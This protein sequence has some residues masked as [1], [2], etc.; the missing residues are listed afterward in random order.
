MP[1]SS[2]SIQT[3]S[4]QIEPKFDNIEL[5]FGPNQLGEKW[6]CVH[7]PRNHAYNLPSTNTTILEKHTPIHDYGLLATNVVYTSKVLSFRM[8]PWMI[9]KTLYS[10]QL[11]CKVLSSTYYATTKGLSLWM[12]IP[13]PTLTKSRVGTLQ[14]RAWQIAFVFS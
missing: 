6:P 11:L 5:T 10:L 7:T 4:M 13:R 9:E 3:S 14:L 1:L 2:I 8:W 12:N